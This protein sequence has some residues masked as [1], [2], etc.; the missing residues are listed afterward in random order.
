[1][2]E[3]KTKLCP[4]CQ[5]TKILSEFTRRTSQNKLIT[6]RIC[7]E[8][9]QYERILERVREKAFDKSLTV[10]KPVIKPVWMVVY[11]SFP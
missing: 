9:E 11:R 1:M 3:L 4:S 7:N 2:S 10:R 8:C 6:H 5:E